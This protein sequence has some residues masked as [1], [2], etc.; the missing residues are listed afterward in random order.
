MRWP[1]TLSI[2]VAREII[3]YTLLG[4]TAISVVMLTR[5]LV[6]V[7]DELIGAGFRF[8]DLATVASLLTTILAIYALPVSFLFGVLLAMGRM[9]ADVESTAM[10]ACGVGIR[11]I[12]LPVFLL[13]GLLSLLTLELAVEVEPAARREMAAAVR[14]M[15][16]RGVSVEAARFNSIG[17]RTVYV[18]GRDDERGLTGIMISDQSDPER[19]FVVFAERG[20]LRFDEARGEFSFRL[21]RGDVHIDQSRDDD[22]YQRVHFDR[23][24]YRFDVAAMLDPS[25][26]LRPREMSLAELRDVVA[27]IDAGEPPEVLRESPPSY[28]TNLH[29]RF[30]MPFAP[31]LFALVG[32]PLGI[33]RRRGA[34]SYGVILC[35]L[36][37]FGYYALHSFCELLATESGYPPQLVWLPN[38]AYAA[39]GAFL[40]ARA[41]RAS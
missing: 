29:R 26:V 25:E 28:A 38:V 37:A 5:S 4:L 36:L 41:R 13:G 30:A 40:L 11:G 32:V 3:T 35:A 21:E 9:A 27:R 20:A 14:R 10:R 8:E 1:R 15:L 31:A 2:Y 34:R 22:R 19:P 16:V 24:E 7:L 23:F 39:V 6:R 12:L 17:D 18:D 33:R